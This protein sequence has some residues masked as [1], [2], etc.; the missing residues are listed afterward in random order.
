MVHY[1]P[2]KISAFTY[3]QVFL[4]KHFND[5]FMSIDKTR[6]LSTSVQRSSTSLLGAI[7]VIPKLKHFI[8]INVKIVC[9]TDIY[10]TAKSCKTTW[11]FEVMEITPSSPTVTLSR[12]VRALASVEGGKK[13]SGA[14]SEG[15]SCLEGSLKH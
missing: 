7:F 1:L 8:N 12:K 2:N 6:E 15:V 14:S 4:F 3:F 13:I 11:N 9:I 10:L 5:A